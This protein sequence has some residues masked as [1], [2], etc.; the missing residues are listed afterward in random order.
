M[1]NKTKS[2]VSVGSESTRRNENSET[3]RLR[4]RISQKAFRARQAL[5]MK[6]LEERLN[7]SSCGD[8]E[9][10]TRLQN[11]NAALRDQLLDCHKKITSLQVSMQGLAD[12]SAIALGI[13][14]LDRISEPEP[15][16]TTLCARCKAA[17]S[18]Q[19]GVV[20]RSAP[21]AHP[22]D[23]NSHNAPFELSNDHDRELSSSSSD[24][25]DDTNAGGHRINDHGQE[26]A[27]DSVPDGS[28]R[29]PVELEQPGEV[30]SP[31]VINLDYFSTDDIS[32]KFGI[33]SSQQQVVHKSTY[34]PSPISLDLLFTEDLG[35][36][37]YNNILET[38][39][40][41]AH[42]S[43]KVRRTNSLFSDHIDALEQWVG[44][45]Y[46]RWTKSPI[47]DEH[48]TSPLALILLTF[49]SIS[50]RSMTAW[51]TYTKA[52]VHLKNLMVWRI[53]KTPDTY[54]KVV[55]SYRP[56]KLQMRVPH[57]S[58]I[59]WIPWPQLRDKVILHHS[60]NPCLDSI[61]CDIGNSYVMPADLSA[62]I[63][64]PQSVLGYVGVWDLVRAM[65]PE[66]TGSPEPQSD[67]NNLEAFQ[68]LTLPAR[69][70]N[71]LFSSQDL[72]AQAFRLLGT[73]KGPFN[74]RLD[75]AFFGRHPE[76]YDPDSDLMALG[77]ALRPCSQA[78][79]PVPRD[80]DLS[81]VGQYQEMSRYLIDVALESGQY[82]QVF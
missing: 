36:L 32:N 30:Q 69:D 43:I 62:L 65:A 81:V 66:A 34:R 56:T 8:T 1:T 51:H 39:P 5:R 60:A 2:R 21:P 37:K 15:A 75:P 76:L 10:V 38:C 24:S 20:L 42:R 47:L 12:A 78:S 4:N 23:A 6:E 13:E 49:V 3:R 70:A 68:N 73:D 77:V 80:L 19:D 26:V 79:V 11:Q 52:H 82:S 74:F 35:P 7:T 48:L 54:L 18:G 71:S 46:S 14:R 28:N 44:W 27:Q 41:F 25:H 22:N 53:Y 67:H 33:F 64:C 50:W 61:I 17:V 57:P 63:R 55:P 29:L 58:I 31:P 9:W 59:D 16:S 45:S 72:A 40:S